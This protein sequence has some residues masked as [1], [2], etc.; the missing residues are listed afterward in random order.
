MNLAFFTRGIGALGPVLSAL[1]GAS[2]RETPT[3]T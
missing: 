1:V 2:K 3:G